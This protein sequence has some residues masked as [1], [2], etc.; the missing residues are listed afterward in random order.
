MRADLARRA[1]APPTA[2]SSG[3]AGRTAGSP[4]TPPT[5]CGCATCAATRALARRRRH[6]QHPSPRQRPGPGGGDRRRRRLRPHRLALAGLR[7]RARTPTRPPRRCRGSGSRSSRERIRTLDLPPPCTEQWNCGSA[8]WDSMAAMGREHRA[9]SA[10]EPRR[11]GAGRGR[12]PAREPSRSPPAARDLGSGDDSSGRG[13]GRVD[14]PGRGRAA[15][16]LDRP[17][18]HRQVPGRRRRPGLDARQVHPGDRDRRQVPGGHQLERVVLRQDAAGARERRRREAA[19]SSSPPTGWPAATTTSA[20]SRTSTCR[21]CRTSRRTCC[22]SFATRTSTPTARSPVPYQSGMTGLI[23]RT[24]LAP[25]IT[26]INDLFDPK[27]KGKVDLL[28]E[29]RDTVPL[30]M[31][32]EGIDPE[33]ATKDQWL[34]DDRQDRGRDRLRPDPRHDRQR[35]RRRPAARRRGRRDRLVGRRRPAAGSTTRR[36]SSGCRTRAAS[37]GPTTW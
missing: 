30:V 5:A 36:S 2:S 8:F 17:A 15:D 25:D 33:T 7:G 12:R 4:S 35:L 21:R 27:Y 14:H 23:V 1:T 32:A 22:R 16:D 34:D 11:R 9:R 3:A 20:T 13:R 10:A 31:K 29:L 26:S 18:L 24:D 19:T 37:S 6:R 28:S